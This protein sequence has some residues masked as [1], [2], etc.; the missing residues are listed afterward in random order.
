MDQ[1]PSF[2]YR[3]KSSLFLIM[4]S[5]SLP[6]LCLLIGWIAQLITNGYYPEGSTRNNWNLL[7]VFPPVGLKWGMCV[8]SPGAQIESDLLFSCIGAPLLCSS[9]RIH[10]QGA[11]ASCHTGCAWGTV[12]WPQSLKMQ[13][14]LLLEPPCQQSDPPDIPNLL[15]DRSTQFW[16]VT[17]TDRVTGMR[18]SFK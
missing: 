13:E 15:A 14:E 7:T 10:P 9:P 11:F 5:S 2:C 8:V 12:T 4:A 18:Y 3:E 6:S 17:R 1:P 16:C